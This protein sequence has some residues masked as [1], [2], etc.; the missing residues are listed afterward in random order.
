MTGGSMNV[1]AWQ[2]AELLGLPKDA[3]EDEINAKLIEDQ[4]AAAEAEAAFAARYF[5]ELGAAVSNGDR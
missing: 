2:M 5:P 3:S 4:V 1:P